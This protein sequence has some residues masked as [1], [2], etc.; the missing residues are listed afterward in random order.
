MD[1]V[2][3]FTSPARHLMVVRVAITD[4]HHRPPPPVTT[5]ARLNVLHLFSILVYCFT[6]GGTFSELLAGQ[7]QGA[8]A[9]QWP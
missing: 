4:H 9:Q 1:V 6:L 7:L 3:I 2:A 8:L 5:S